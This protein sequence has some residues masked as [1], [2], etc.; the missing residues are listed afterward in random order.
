MPNMAREMNFDGLVGPT[1]N[2]GGF[3]LGNLASTRSAGYTS[4][5]KQAA[6]QG[7]AKMR[8]LY[9]LGIPQGI[10]P[11]HFRP[12]LALARRLG[13]EGDDPTLLQT[14]WDTA[15]K[16]LAA[17][18]SA[19]AMWTANAATVCPSADAADGRLHLT[20]ANLQNQLH[21]SIE[22]R[23]T[24]R[25]LSAIFHDEARFVVHEPLPS[26]AALGDEGA[27]NHTRFC[28]EYGAPGLQLFVFGQVAT[29]P[30]LPK[31]RIFPSRQTREASESIARLHRL[32]EERII[33]AQQNPDAIDAGVFHNDV[34]S[35][36]DRDVFFYH[37]KAFLD[38]GETIRALQERFEQLT[39]DRLRT[40]EVKDKDL[41][42]DACVATYLFNSQLVTLAGG[43]TALVC[44]KECEENAK[45]HALLDDLVADDTCP[46]AQVHFHDVRQSMHGGGGP[47]CLRL[48]VV[49]T[50]EELGALPE[51]IVLTPEVHAKLESW[52]QT[53]YRDALAPK[54]LADPALLEE[55]RVALDALTSLLGIGS[56]YDFQLDGP[57]SPATRA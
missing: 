22:A 11:P 13:F 27:A 31:P 28:L 49:L 45:A 23:T 44:P 20:P 41:D 18:Y 14:L 46:I 56:I 36:G 43:E 57:G 7:L 52:V 30:W 37:E 2:H 9:D 39:G 15:P 3:A 8:A 29:E 5:P 33:F 19:S 10:L 32:P 1:F 25:I 47:A 50:D 16:A 12:D 35:V 17:C 4:S 54:D 55:S 42:V 24:R 51:S 48:R 34:I 38:T 26:S 21:R 6:L 40:V 53:H